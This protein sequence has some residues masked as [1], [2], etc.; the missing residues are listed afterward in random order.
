MK[1][2]GLEIIKEEKVIE[3]IIP[4][5]NWKEHLMKRIN[6]MDKIYTIQK[7]TIEPFKIEWEVF[8]K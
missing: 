3:T 6:E 8:K 5:E 1:I 7:I 2:F 4:T